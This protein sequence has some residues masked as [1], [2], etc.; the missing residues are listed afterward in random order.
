MPDVCR[1]DPRSRLA[2]DY[3]TNLFYSADD[4]GC[5][6]GGVDEVGDGSHLRLHISCAE[7]AGPEI[8]ARF[9]HGDG[10]KPSLIGLSGSPKWIATRDTVVGMSS[11]FAPRS[12]ASM[13]DTRSPSTTASTPIRGYGREAAINPQRDRL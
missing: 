1:N 10:V 7:L 13:P 5:A 3:G 9:A 12:C 11:M 4:T 8:R 2:V 6:R